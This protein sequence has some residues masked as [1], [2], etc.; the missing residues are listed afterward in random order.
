MRVR[1][2]SAWMAM[3]R[4]CLVI[5]MAIVVGLWHGSKSRTAHVVSDS[6]DL[7]Q[8]QSEVPPEGVTDAYDRRVLS[9][10]PVMYLTLGHPWSGTEEDLSGNGHEGVYLPADD[11]PAVAYLPNGDPAASFNGQRQ[12]VQVA[13]ASALSV[14]N[15]GCLS[16]QAWIQ[17]ATLQFRHQHASAYV[18]LLGKGMSGKQE[19]ALRMYSRS[20]DVVPARPNRVSAYAFNLRGGLGSGSYFQDAISIGQWFMVT[21]VIDDRASLTWPD[22][23]VAIYKDGS[24]RGRVSLGQFDVRPRASDAPLRIATRD[25]ESYF[26]GAIGKVAIYDYVLSESDIAGTYDAME[27][28]GL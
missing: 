26:Q 23:Y 19:Y 28:L 1:N 8:P 27:P 21:F 5:A 25:L 11:P 10:A 4:V 18:Y 13:S 12:Y 14:T 9:L 22:G 3:A 15:T 17:P 16:L 20:N 6:G 24:L 7:C 2:L